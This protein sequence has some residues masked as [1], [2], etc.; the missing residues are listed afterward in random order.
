MRRA[1]RP[2][3]LAVVAAALVFSAGCGGNKDKLV[4]KWKVTESGG[5]GAMKGDDKGYAYF[6]F[7]K[8]GTFKFGL[9]ITDPAEKEKAG[10]FIELFT[11]TGKYTVDGD[12][13]QLQPAD[14]K[15]KEGPFKKDAKATLKFDGNDKLTITAPDGDMKLTRMK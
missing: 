5:K 6:D 7:A 15:D 13:L 2:F 1:H 10:K 4:G 8:D 9:E 12:K 11:F 3:A 14:G